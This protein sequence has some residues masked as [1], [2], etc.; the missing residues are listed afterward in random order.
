MARLGKEKKEEIRK[1]ILMVS[2]DLF[3]SRGYENTSTNE[4]AKT[5]GIAEGT[6]FNYFKAK[7]DIFLEIMSVDFISITPDELQSID[8]TAGVAD[9]LMKFIEKSMKSIMI[10]P[11]RILTELG[12]ALMH[13]A[14]AKPDL[15][16]KLADIDFRF[17][18]QTNEIIRK[19]QQQGIVKPCDTRVFSEAVYSVLIFEFLMYIYE[20][21]RS[22]D[23]AKEELRKKLEFICKGYV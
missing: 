18:D 5:V 2:K 4:I 9:I 20:K 15:I 17:M 22:V 7:A 11:K 14:K 12:I 16:K 19:L 13:T 1:K 10:L 3:L 8:F 21:E 23:S 6:I